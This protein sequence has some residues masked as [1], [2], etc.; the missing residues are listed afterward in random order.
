MPLRLEIESAIS[1]PTF[2]GA[3]LEA[4][5]RP[6][7]ADAPGLAE[8]LSSIDNSLH[9]ADAS[10]AVR[11]LIRAAFL[12]ELVNPE[13]TSTK[14]EYRWTDRLSQDPRGAEYE[15][16]LEIFRKLMT[17]LSHEAAQRQTLFGRFRQLKVLPYELPV[18]YYDRQAGH[19]ERNI[20]WIWDAPEIEPTLALRALVRDATVVGQLVPVFGQ[21]L[22]N[23]IKVKTYLTDRSQTGLHQTNREKRW[24]YAPAGVQYAS[25]LD[26]LRIEH[27]LLS[28]LCF[29]EGFPE[30]V[31]DRLLASGAISAMESPA[32]C[33]V[34]RDALDFEAFR[35][36]VEVPEMGRSAFQVGHLNPLKG[37]GSGEQFGH[38]PENVSWI[39]DDGN[40]IQGPLSYVETMGLLERCAKNRKAFGPAPEAA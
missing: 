39:S 40:R 27:K 26:C 2:S 18:D 38:T 9:D 1:Q 8:P 17:A 10:Y 35:K 5:S 33:P 15:E 28:Q 16:C 6:L 22:K 21:A 37:P 36:G 19:T 32:R 13:N 24:E 11:G 4:V 20:G 29:F 3:Q 23:K 34:T 31:R 25:R 14:F 12:I 30:D 7:L